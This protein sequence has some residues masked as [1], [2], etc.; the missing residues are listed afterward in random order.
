MDGQRRTGSKSKLSYASCP[1]RIKDGLY[2]GDKFS[3]KV[4]I[5]TF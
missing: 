4:P 5:V 3:A 2:I 1:I